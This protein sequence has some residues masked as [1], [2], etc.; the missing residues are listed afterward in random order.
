MNFK[1]LSSKLMLTVV[2]NVVPIKPTAIAAKGKR[3]YLTSILIF[4]SAEGRR[5]VKNLH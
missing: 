5:W 3:T 2:E 4:P 1:G